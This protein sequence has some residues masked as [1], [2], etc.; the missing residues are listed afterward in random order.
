MQ[1]ESADFSGPV[2][3]SQGSGFHGEGYLD[4]K[5][6][7]GRVNWYQENDGAA[8]P[9]TLRFRYAA[10]DP[11]GPRTMDLILNGRKVATLVVSMDTTCPAMHTF[12]NCVRV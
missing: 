3:S 10:N 2:I 8:G 1:A 11:V 4:F 5:R 9:F 12:H 6:Q 7:E